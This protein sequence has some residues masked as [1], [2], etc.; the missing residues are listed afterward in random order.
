MWNMQ[1][2]EEL[3]EEMS[4]TCVVVC[5]GQVSV[6]KHD[7]MTFVH[8]ASQL[9]WLSD[10]LEHAYSYDILTKSPPIL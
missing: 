2:I 9:V 8:L 4:W 7:L 6:I 5:L 10:I 1:T 3:D